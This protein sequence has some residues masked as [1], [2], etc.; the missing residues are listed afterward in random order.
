MTTRP[1]RR[2]IGERGPE[3]VAPLHR[4]PELLGKMVGRGRGGDSVSVSIGALAP[5][6]LD[7][8]PHILGKIIGEGTARAIQRDPGVRRTVAAVGAG[9]L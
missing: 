1:Q 3:L 6:L 8:P 5:G 4:V 2:L 7:L 9:R